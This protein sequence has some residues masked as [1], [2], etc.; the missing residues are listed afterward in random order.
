M[1]VIASDRVMKKPCK[2]RVGQEGIE[3]LVREITG[4]I[5]RIAALLPRGE[6]AEKHQRCR[7]KEENASVV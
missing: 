3:R 7:M 4:M 6:T 2:D 5:Q 1:L